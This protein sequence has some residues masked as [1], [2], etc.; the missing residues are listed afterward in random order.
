VTR[1]L[2]SLI[3]WLPVFLLP[4]IGVTYFFIDASTVVQECISYGEDLGDFCVTGNQGWTWTGVIVA[5]LLTL[6]ALAYLVWNLGYKQG[7]TGSS[8]GKGMQKFKIVSE[9]TGQPVG[10]GMSLVRALI[11]WVAYGVCGILWLVAVL[12]PLWDPKRQTLVD[13]LLKTVA[14]P[15]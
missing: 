12:F 2:A 6:I 3:D 11:Y 9:A 14:V 7:T 4:T 15:I 1:L 13:K 8:L 10:F 5:L